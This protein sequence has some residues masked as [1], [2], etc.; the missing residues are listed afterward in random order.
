MNIKIIDTDKNNL[1]FLSLVKLLNIELREANGEIQKQFEK[2]NSL[3]N[4]SDVFVIYDNITPIACGGLREYNR[5][6]VEIKR[7][8]VL[9]AYRKMQLGIK[10]MALLEERAKIKGYKTAI[11]ET[12]VKLIAA[13]NLYYKLGYVDSEN[14]REGLCGL[15]MKKSL[16]Y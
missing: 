16:L 2:H 11:L 5:D 9:P 8:F 4:I 6:I 3:E 12:S 1:G 10:I 13:A 14:F 7:V 15:W